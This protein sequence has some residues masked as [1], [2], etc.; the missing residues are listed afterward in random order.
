MYVRFTDA[1]TLDEQKLDIDGVSGAEQAFQRN[2]AA[3]SEPLSLER[4]VEDGLEVPQHLRAELKKDKI[5]LVGHSWGAAVG[6]HMIK[7]RPDRF[8]AFVDVSVPVNFQQGEAFIYRR[9]LALA[10]QLQDAE[11]PESPHRAWPGSLQ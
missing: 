2:G 8:S 6:I 3:N 1:S 10:L 9:I 7:R 11:A 5:L 4:I